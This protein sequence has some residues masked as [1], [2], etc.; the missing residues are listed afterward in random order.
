MRNRLTEKCE[1][2]AEFHEV[3]SG[4]GRAEIIGSFF[5]FQYGPRS[6]FLWA[7]GLGLGY[8]FS[9]FLTKEN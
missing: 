8:L 1:N 4:V 2:W 9:L 3:S 6:E 5:M 7:N